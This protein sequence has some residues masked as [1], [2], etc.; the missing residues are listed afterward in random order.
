MG[1]TAGYC[2]ICGHVPVGTHVARRTAIPGGVLMQ[3]NVRMNRVRK[4]NFPIKE[5]LI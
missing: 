5:D 1:M 4:I 2:A 3:K